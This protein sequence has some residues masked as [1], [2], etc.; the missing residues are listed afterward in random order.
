MAIARDVHRIVHE[1]FVR[2]FDRQIAGPVERY[3]DVAESIWGL[4]TAGGERR[5]S[6]PYVSVKATAGCQDRLYVDQRNPKLN[7]LRLIDELTTRLRLRPEFLPRWQAAEGGA[8]ARLEGELFEASKTPAAT[9]PRATGPPGGLTS[10]A[11]TREP[12]F[13]RVA[14]SPNVMGPERRRRHLPRCE[15]GRRSL[16]ASYTS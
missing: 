11:P 12:Y 7:R 3:R 8:A 2:W 13:H 14:R 15:P 10:K 1:E 4:W 16:R 6:D 5:R 9:R